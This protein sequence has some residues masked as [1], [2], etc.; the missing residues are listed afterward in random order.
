MKNSKVITEFIMS[1][2][3]ATT[4]I[5]I[6]MGILGSFFMKEVVFGYDA[7][8][9]PPIFGFFSVCLSIVNYSKKELS[10][11]QVIVRKCIHLLLINVLVFGLNYDY[12]M[13]FEPIFALC[14]FLFIFVIYVTVNVLIWLNDR[15][16]AV[17]FNKELI[18][19]QNKQEMKY[20]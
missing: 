8:F 16:T 5:G 18:E 6:C 3:I 7:F 1:F 11:K 12:G 15:K 14:L 17:Q 13:I 4:C 10:I 19:F 2:F 9:S 20:N